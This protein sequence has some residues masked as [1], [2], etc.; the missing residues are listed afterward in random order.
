MATGAHDHRMPSARFAEALKIAT[1]LPEEE[2]AELARELVRTLPEDLELEDDE[3]GFSD[4]W[5][6][7]IKRRLRDEPRGEA[8]TFDQLRERVDKMISRGE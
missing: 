1:E 8:L 5:K 3:D 6:V 4:E 7:E 2:R